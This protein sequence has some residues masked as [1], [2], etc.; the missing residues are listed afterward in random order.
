MCGNM[1]IDIFQE[2][3]KAIVIIEISS[4]QLERTR[5]FAADYAI[6]TNIAIDHGDSHTSPEAYLSAKKNIF[7]INNK[8]QFFLTGREYMK[9]FSKIHCH[10]HINLTNLQIEKLNKINPL[11]VQKHNLINVQNAITIVQEIK[12]TNIDLLIDNLKDFKLPRFRQEIFYWKNKTII[13]DSKC[14][15]VISCIASMQNYNEFIWIAGGVLKNKYFDYNLNDILKYKNQIKKA[16]FFGK[17]K[18]IFFDF[19]KAY[20]PCTLIELKDSV[21]FIEQYNINT[22]LFSPI[23]QSFDEF[24][25]YIERGLFF[26]SL[27]NK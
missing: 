12:N 20:F 25:N 8:K 26:N 24:K 19:F 15:N 13:N 17:N 7:R 18:D 21:Y 16:L 10:S 2:I 6:L 1:G 22:V 9:H 4:K 27:F 23:G 5:Y 14:T 3:D 11:L